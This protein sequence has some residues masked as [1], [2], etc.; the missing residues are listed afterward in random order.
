MPGQIPR[1][2]VW[3]LVE[4]QHGVIARRQ[5]LGLGFTP[6]TIDRRVAAG[7]LHCLWRGIYAVGRPRVTLRGWWSAA[8]LACGDGAL[9]SHLSAARLWGIWGTKTSGEEELDQPSHTDVSV[10]SGKT[11]RLRGIR[12][13]RRGRLRDSDRTVC[14]WIPATI[15]GRTLV[16]LATLLR[17][18]Q[19][20]AAVNAADKLELIDPET[21]R[22][23][24]ERNRGMDGVPALR[25]ILDRRTFTLTDSELERKFLQLVRHAGLPPPLTQQRVNGFRVDFLWSQWKLV[26]ETD[27]LRYHRTPGQQAKDRLRDQALV[28]AGFTALR[29]T[30]AQV[31][32]DPDHVVKMLR[33]VAKSISMD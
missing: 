2:S 13:H 20:E 26:V 29:F 23:E 28:A 5:L 6:K 18:S 12:V 22:L 1:N 33:A 8:V 9:L 30:H 7:R 16:D 24:L 11:H 27:G 4:R 21:L 31:T 14:E 3:Q 25:R 10:A 32:Y 15:P 17:P 19:L